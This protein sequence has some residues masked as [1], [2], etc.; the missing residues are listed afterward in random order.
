MTNTDY[1]WVKK[2]DYEM[3]FSIAKLALK[4]GIYL[5]T[6]QKLHIKTSPERATISP[7]GGMEK[8]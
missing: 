5:K 1:V 7:C 2:L 4:Q 6:I 8:S 3:F